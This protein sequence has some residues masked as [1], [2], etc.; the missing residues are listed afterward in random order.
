MWPSYLGL[1][2]ASF[3]PLRALQQRVVSLQLCQLPAQAVHFVLELLVVL[4]DVN[5]FVI[6]LVQTLGGA[7]PAQKHSCGIRAKEKAT[8]IVITV[9]ISQSKAL[10]HYN[11]LITTIAL[12]CNYE[13]Y[14]FHSLEFGLKKKGIFGA[15]CE[16]LRASNTFLGFFT[17]SAFQHFKQFIMSQTESFL[18]QQ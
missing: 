8:L 2:P 5:H 18:K 10:P 16:C 17:F 15:K 7:A 9:I 4:D 6:G 1:G 11:H 13:H 14:C 3:L 12:L